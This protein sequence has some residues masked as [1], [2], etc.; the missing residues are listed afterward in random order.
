MLSVTPAFP[1]RHAKMSAVKKKKN[2]NLVDQWTAMQGI[3]S[4][5]MQRTFSFAVKLAIV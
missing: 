1:A 2:D 5:H 4:L 3:S